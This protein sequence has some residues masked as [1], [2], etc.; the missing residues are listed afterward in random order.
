MSSPMSLPLPYSPHDIE[1]REELE[2]VKHLSAYSIIIYWV[3]CDSEAVMVRKNIAHEYPVL[4]N[5]LFYVNTAGAS[6]LVQHLERDGIS[7][8]L[9]V[10]IYRNGQLLDEVKGYDVIQMDR[11]FENIEH[12]L[13]PTAH[14]CW[15]L[16]HPESADSTNFV[17]YPR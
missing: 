1:T 12:E 8:A 9:Q 2:R 7:R 17:A 11:I 14:P 16:A 6:P 13:D 10:R 5:I 15:A 3:P 4:R